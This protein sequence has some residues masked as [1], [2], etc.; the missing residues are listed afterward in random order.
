[1]AQ[2]DTVTDGANGSTAGNTTDTIEVTAAAGV[3][4]AFHLL[5]IGAK[6]F[7]A[8][9]ARN[10]QYTDTGAG[11]VWASGPIADNTTVMIGV[12]NAADGGETWSGKAFVDDTIG[13]R[14]TFNNDNC[15]AKGRSYAIAGQEVK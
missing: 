9:G 5:Y 3:N 7:A 10:I 1:M 12:N 15:S 11:I 8:T 6:G 14:I 13:L 2:G 4:V